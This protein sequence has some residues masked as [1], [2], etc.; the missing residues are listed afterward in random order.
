MARIY[1]TGHRNPDLDTL[2]AASS[3]ANLKNL[4]DPANEYIPV[5]CSPVSDSVRDQMNA[6]EL[7]IP[8]Y[9]KDVY[10]KAR[11]VML[12]SGLNM[13]ASDPIYDL[14][15]S[16]S[17]DMP[18]VIPIYNGDDFKGLLSVDDITAWFLEENKDH[19]R[20]YEFSADNILNVLPTELVHRGSSDTIKGRLIV[21]AAD[22]DHFCGII[23][24]Y[25]DCIVVTGGRR[26]HIEY[27]LS[28]QVPAIVV[29]AEGD[30]TGVDHTDYKGYIFRTDIGT[31][32]AIRKIRLCECVESVSATETEMMD[33]D[34]KFTEAKR[35]LSNSKSRGIAICRPIR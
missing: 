18:P 7:E 20:V 27:A 3:Y 8:S 11:D 15:N 5:H 29:T 31:T 32:D 25:E 30:L 17:I 2:C 21:G 4:I 1:V 28:R 13:Q 22:F 24:A 33:A 35:I 23:D 9:K 6:M 34:E 12:T 26:E 19:D 10:P 14:I 16:Y